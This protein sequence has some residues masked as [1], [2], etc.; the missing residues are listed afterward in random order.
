MPD[1]LQSPNAQSAPGQSESTSAAAEN[2]GLSYKFQRLREKLRQA[3]A[4]GELSGKLPGERA[5]AKRFSVNAKTL[6]KALTDLAAEGLLERSIGRGS[7]VKGSAPPVAAGKGWLVVCESHQ[8]SCEI[9]QLLRAAQPDLDVVTDLTAVRPSYLNQFSAV[10][11]LSPSTPE[12]FIRD[13]LVRNMPVVVVGKEPKTY[14]THSVTFDGPLA[15]AQLAR[16]LFLA[17]H[18]RMAAIDPQNCTLI[19]TGLRQAAARYAPGAIVEAG[20]AR[21]ALTLVEN[22]I[23][24]FVCQNVD[25]ALQVKQLLEA[26][27]IEVPRHVSLAAIG[28]TSFDPPVSG[29]FMPR[30]QEA[31]AI[32]QLLNRPSARP[33]AIWLAGQFVDRGTL[34]SISDSSGDGDDL[35]G[36]SRDSETAA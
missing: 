33:T 14:S 15:V 1:E 3:I 17:G 19:A 26:G 31:A 20:F 24:A 34:C 12:N 27:G 35:M 16:D 21:D 5:L 11:D 7:F 2:S 9:I 6:S 8:R 13:L 32:V 30:A 4:S 22:R 18:R 28:A 25:L 23:T 10:I 29:Y 36:Y